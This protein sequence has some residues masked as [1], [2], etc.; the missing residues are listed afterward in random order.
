MSPKRQNAEPPSGFRY[1]SE[2]LEIDEERVL[3]DRI[4]GLPLS[5]FEFH[6]YLAKRRVVYFGYQ[7]RYDENALRPAEEIPGFLL[8]LRERAAE[9]A[10]MPAGDLVHAMVAEYRSGTQIG[11]H[12][13]KPVFGEVIGVSLCSPC[14]FRFRRRVESGFERYSRI[15]EP[16]SVY[17]LSGPART[18]WHH[19]IPAVSAL[20]YSV[21]FRTLAPGRS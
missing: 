17:L 14:L 4:R 15:A 9:F 3:V 6:G 16:R 18:D 20:R 12:R 5:E 8:P 10:G 1:R 21:T 13:D 19:S 11:W 2:L 7:Y